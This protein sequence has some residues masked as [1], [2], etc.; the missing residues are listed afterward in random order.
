LYALE[1]ERYHLTGNDRVGNLI[2]AFRELPGF[3]TYTDRW[4]AFIKD[5]L[6]G[7][8]LAVWS[9]LRIFLSGWKRKNSGGAFRK[10]AG[11]RSKGE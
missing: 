2:R 11:R 7:Y 9:G 4:D 5:L 8:A 1:Y 3:L 6:V 10:A